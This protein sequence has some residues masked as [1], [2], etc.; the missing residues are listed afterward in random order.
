MF[1]QIKFT[2]PMKPLRNEEDKVMDFTWFIQPCILSFSICSN[3]FNTL[4]GICPHFE[5][6]LPISELAALKY[7]QSSRSQ[8]T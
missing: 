3:F 7:F 1:V 4:F 8:F 5:S 2:E 6:I